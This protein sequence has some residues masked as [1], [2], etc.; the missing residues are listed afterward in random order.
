MPTLTEIR[1]AEGMAVTSRTQTIKNQG[2]QSLVKPDRLAL[3]CFRG[4]F[5]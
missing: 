4:F 1:T 3:F 2:Y 5:A